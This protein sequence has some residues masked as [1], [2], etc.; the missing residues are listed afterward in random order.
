MFAD[1]VLNYVNVGGSGIWGNTGT[2][3]NSDNGYSAPLALA[4]FPTCN[5][6][7]LGRLLYDNTNSVWRFCDGSF[8]QAFATSDTASWTAY[9]PGLSTLLNLPFARYQHA[10]TTL[11]QGTSTVV[12]DNG[13]ALVTGVGAGN[14]VFTIYDITAASLTSA[15]LTVACTASVGSVTAGSGTYTLTAPGGAH[16]YEMRL[17]SNGCTTLP[18]LN[19]TVRF[20]ASRPGN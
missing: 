2:Y 16:T 12:I 9:F 3:L 5:G 8:W 17:T 14:A 13:V 15:T 20:T 6:T 18:Q 4:S 1:T 10:G 11:V 19:V 7:T